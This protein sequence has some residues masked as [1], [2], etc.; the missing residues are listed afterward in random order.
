VATAGGGN[1]H[2]L[3]PKRAKKEH[4]FY[5]FQTIGVN[6]EAI[7]SP[8][9]AP[10]TSLAKGGKERKKN[11]RESSFPTKFVVILEQT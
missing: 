2:H 3:L 4:Y 11:R 6:G 8:F 7:V 1:Q 10:Q 9:P 5:Y